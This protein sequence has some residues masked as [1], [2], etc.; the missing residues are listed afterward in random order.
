MNT[1]ANM[2]THTW[3]WHYSAMVPRLIQTKTAGS[4]TLHEEEDPREQFMNKQIYN[5]D[6][7]KVNID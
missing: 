2:K 7:L 3:V 6:K 5:E 1:F 4:G